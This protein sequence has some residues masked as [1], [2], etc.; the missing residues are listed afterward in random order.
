VNRLRID[1]GTSL[2]WFSTLT[3]MTVSVILV[4]SSALHQY[5]FARNLKDYIEQLTT[6]SLTLWDGKTDISKPVALIQEQFPIP[7]EDFRITY[8][9]ILPGPT[10]K[11][12]GC[13]T[14][15]SPLPII[16]LTIELCQQALAR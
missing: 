12:V 6:A 4:L 1:A 7:I 15:R 16:D 3:G 11:L 13:G 14:W 9:E 10:L 5:L 8:A 2:I